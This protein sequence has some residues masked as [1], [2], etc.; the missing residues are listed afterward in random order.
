MSATDH[1]GGLA[2]KEPKCPEWM[3]GNGVSIAMRF[4]ISSGSVLTHLQDFELYSSLCRTKK[5]LP[6]DAD[7]SLAWKIDCV[8]HIETLE[9][10]CRVEVDDGYG[11]KSYCGV[12]I[13]SDVSLCC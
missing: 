2:T 13:L 10:L 7:M 1:R 8:N 3:R 12:S 11:V 9:R 4:K 5:P 6:V